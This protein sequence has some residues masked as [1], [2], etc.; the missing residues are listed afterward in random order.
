M[1]A[2]TNLL[3]LS[4]QH[5]VGQAHKMG[6]CEGYQARPSR[7]MLCLAIQALC[8]LASLHGAACIDGPKDYRQKF[9]V[10]REDFVISMPVDQKHLTVAKGSRAWR[11][12]TTILNPSPIGDT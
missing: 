8:L 9:K 5:T 12:V 6:P 11:Q 7:S 2:C 3:G 4:G 10:G 1:Q